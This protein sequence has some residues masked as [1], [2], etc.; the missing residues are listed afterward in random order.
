MADSQIGGHGTLF[1][2]ATLAIVILTGNVFA[3]FITA[4]CAM[5]LVVI[6]NLAAMPTK[7]TVPVFFFS[8]LIDIAVIVTAILL[9]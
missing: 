5:V 7:V 8:L 3:L 6:V 4:C 1:T 2:I 9:H